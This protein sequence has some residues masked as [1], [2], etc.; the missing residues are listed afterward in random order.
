MKQ[1][2]QLYKI[3]EVHFDVPVRGVIRLGR[4]MDGLVPEYSDTF[5]PG[6]QFLAWASGID[7]TEEKKNYVYILHFKPF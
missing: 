6:C 3:I 1:L 5:G 4:K 7:C 2:E